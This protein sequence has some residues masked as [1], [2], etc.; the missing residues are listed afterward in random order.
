MRSIN[1]LPLLLL[2]CSTMVFAQSDTT[3]VD[4]LA[5]KSY[6][7]TGIRIGTDML[8][9]ARSMY[10]SKTFT[11]WEVNADVDFDRYYLAVDYGYWARTFDGDKS[12]YDNNGTYF[13][14]GPDVNFLTKDPEK[15]M[16]FFG[17][18]YGH[19]TFSEHLKIEN[20]QDPVWGSLDTQV[21]NVNING[22]WF[23]LVT[24]LKVKM[25][26]FIWMGYTARFKFGL[27]TNETG[28][29]KPS[30]V[31]GY[32]STDKQSTWGFNYQLF[33]RI[34]APIKHK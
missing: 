34:P 20:V 24:G 1:I 32:G 29:M 28:L 8:S 13:R 30:D 25:W 4:S 3:K 10:S 17:L 21:A 2:V 9:I 5:K 19:A 16:F 22:N 23:E 27:S 18:R 12:S 33:F 14:V 6:I 26:K 15:N 31:P 7:P 11:G